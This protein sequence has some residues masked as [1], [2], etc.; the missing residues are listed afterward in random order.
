MPRGGQRRIDTSKVSGAERSFAKDSQL[1]LFRANSLF[2]NVSI[3]RGLSETPV[4]ELTINWQK[5][6][7]SA[8]TTTYHLVA[9][10]M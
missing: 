3:I 10:A 9:V 8:T 4:F 1:Q 5:L 7:A 2:I 6:L